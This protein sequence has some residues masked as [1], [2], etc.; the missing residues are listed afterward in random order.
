MLLIVGWKHSEIIS[1]ITNNKVN[2]YGLFGNLKKLWT[3][4]IHMNPLV[5][6][7]ASVWTK[8]CVNDILFKCSFFNKNAN[9]NVKMHIN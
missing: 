1:R 6:R 8:G 2:L 4:V 9:G 3:R 7:M 5:S